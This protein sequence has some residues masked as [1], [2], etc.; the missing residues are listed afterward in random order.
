MTRREFHWSDMPDLYRICLLTGDNGSDATGQVD[1]AI[2]G[3]IFAAP[4]AVF[5]PELCTIQLVDHQPSG[6]ILGVKDSKLFAEL[7]EKNW[8][9]PLRKKYPRPEAKDTSRQAEL[10]RAIH[11]GYRYSPGVIEDYPAH[12]HIDLLPNAQ[13]SGLGVALMNR[14]LD[15][16]R[17]QK[18]P[19]V[20]LGVSKK[21]ERA[22]KW[23]PRFGYQILSENNDGIVY[24]LKL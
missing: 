2:L 23:Y 19:G 15:Q 14:F 21:N 13:G 6:Y 17:E 1:D 18:V 5:E 3:H 24:G 11:E 16:L 4:Y 8:W 10:V 20:H 22:V 12:L 7:T 9:G